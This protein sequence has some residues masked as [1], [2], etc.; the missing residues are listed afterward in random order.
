MKPRIDFPKLATIN[1][2]YTSSE[3]TKTVWHW[4]ENRF[5]GLPLFHKSVDLR[6]KYYQKIIEHEKGRLTIPHEIHKKVSP[7]LK[8]DFKSLLTYLDSDSGIKNFGLLFLSVKLRP[9][10]LKT[11]IK[12][13]NSGILKVLQPIYWW[14]GQKTTT[15]VVLAI[16]SRSNNCCY[17][18]LA[19]GIRGV[20]HYSSILNIKKQETENTYTIKAGLRVF[21]SPKHLNHPVIAKI[22]SFSKTKNILNDYINHHLVPEKKEIV[23]KLCQYAFNGCMV[24]NKNDFISSENLKK[25]INIPTIHL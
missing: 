13:K 15:T 6:V 19:V 24:R 5:Y 2:R 20:S 25:T 11:Q 21:V 16:A 7:H 22:L 12:K 14:I 18:S 3:D 4:M 8:A 10:L 23:S 1:L 9:N 17:E